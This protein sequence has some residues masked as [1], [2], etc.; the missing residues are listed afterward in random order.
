MMTANRME[1]FFNEGE[2]I[3]SKIDIISNVL[4]NTF[5]SVREEKDLAWE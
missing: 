3:K 4:R 2:H 5:Q 1:I